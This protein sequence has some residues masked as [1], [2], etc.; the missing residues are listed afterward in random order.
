MAALERGTLFS[1]ITK[2]DALNAV[3]SSISVHENPS[4]LGNYVNYELHLFLILR[5][6][7][8]QPAQ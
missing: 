8:L 3:R 5:C 6:T 1:S 4:D 7:I 2:L